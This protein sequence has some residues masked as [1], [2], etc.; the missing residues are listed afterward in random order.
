M[1]LP[2]SSRTS[3]PVFST[4]MKTS[5]ERDVHYVCIDPFNALRKQA[6][7]KVIRSPTHPQ[8]VEPSFLQ[9]ESGSRE[10]QC[11]HRGKSYCVLER[12][13]LDRAE[14]R[15]EARYE[16]NSQAHSVLFRP[17][18]CKKRKQKGKKRNQVDQLCEI[19]KLA[20]GPRCST[21]QAMCAVVASL[22]ILAVYGQLVLYE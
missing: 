21:E 7:F 15:C 10:D 20:F 13:K 12:S 3:F 14:Q 16:T 1:W 17:V 8:L 4:P 6:K 11:G 9:G 19:R 2:H 18:P 22:Y 5:S